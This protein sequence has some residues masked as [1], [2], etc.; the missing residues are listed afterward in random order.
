MDTQTSVP[1]ANPE[2]VQQNT[3]TDAAGRMQAAVD[4]ANASQMPPGNALLAPTNNPAEPV[5]AGMA[6]GPGPGPEA[7]PAPMVPDN[8]DYTELLRYLPMMEALADQPT[9]TYA[10][11]NF[12]R[13]L[14][15]SIPP[16]LTMADLVHTN[17]NNVVSG[18]P[19]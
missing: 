17:P 15:G 11:R 6:F 16:Q 7:V 10:T 12:V 13:K 8:P 2:G 9:A 3:V 14:R 19:R 1:M 4:A 5:T 18:Q